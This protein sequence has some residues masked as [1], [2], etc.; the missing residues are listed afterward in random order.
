MES[1]I[2]EANCDAQIKRLIS[3]NCSKIENASGS[4]EY[5]H[6]HRDWGETGDGSG[7]K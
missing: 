3:D 7:M 4:R 1:S 2:A 5:V 6:G